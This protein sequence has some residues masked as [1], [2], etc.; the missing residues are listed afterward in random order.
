MGSSLLLLRLKDLYINKTIKYLWGWCIWLSSPADI[1]LYGI[2]Q[3][4]DDFPLVCY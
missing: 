3:Q 2:L 1:V 4:N